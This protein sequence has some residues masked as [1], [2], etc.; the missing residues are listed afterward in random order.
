[1]MHEA[2][3][4]ARGAGRPD[5]VR[6]SC[7]R[8]R[9]ARG[10]SGKD[11]C[12]T[13]WPLVASALGVPSRKLLNSPNSSHL[14]FGPARI[15]FFKALVLMLPYGRRGRLP[16]LAE[17]AGLGRH[18]KARPVVLGPVVG[19]VL[20]PVRNGGLGRT[21]PYE[22]TAENRGLHEHIEVVCLAHAAALL[23]LGHMP[24]R[25]G[26]DG[27]GRLVCVFARTP[28]VHE[29][30]TRFSMRMEV[31]GDLARF[32]TALNALRDMA[33][34]RRPLPVLGVGHECEL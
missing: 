10:L 27:L 33:K 15:A 4:R 12:M 18:E 23:A 31:P 1:M 9:S 25:Y 21:E 26:R 29:L 28:E 17:W 30:L 11:N 8:G 5:G 3:G 7:A 34:G 6:G 32:D 20:E 2:A 16:F 13:S 22:M 14:Q 24:L 19:C